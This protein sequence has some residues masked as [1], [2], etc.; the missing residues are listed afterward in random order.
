ML[1]SR[2]VRDFGDAREFEIY[3]FIDGKLRES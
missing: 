3:E 1:L 2:L